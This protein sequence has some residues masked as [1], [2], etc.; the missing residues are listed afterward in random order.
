[1]STHGCIFSCLH[2]RIPKT[3]SLGLFVLISS[4]VFGQ[5][6]AAQESEHAAGYETISVDRWR[7]DLHFLVDTLFRRHANAF[8]TRS[9]KDLEDS[10]RALNDGLS[11]M[12]PTERIVEFARF[13]A[14]VGDGHTRMWLYE[15]P[16]GFHPIRFRRYPIRVYWFEEGLYVLGISLQSSALLGARVDSIDNV[17]VRE[18]L[19]R[20]GSLI[21]HDNP[22]GVLQYSPIYLTTPEVLHALKL[23]DSM[24]KSTWVA[25]TTTGRKLSTVLEPVSADYRIQYLSIPGFASGDRLFQEVDAFTLKRHDATVVAQ[26]NQMSNSGKTKLRDFA[27]DLL[28]GLDSTKARR[29]VVDLRYNSGG[30]ASL[31]RP[32]IDEVAKRPSVNRRGGLFVL[33]GRAT[34]SAALW[35]CLDFQRRTNA[36]LIGEPTSGKPNGFGET[37]EFVLPNTGL[38]FSVATRF[39]QRSTPD[40]TRPWLPPDVGVSLSLA[41]VVRGKDRAL[42]AALKWKPK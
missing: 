4:S 7:E 6:S 16:K 18:A 2:R 38:R 27:E 14:L 19:E 36:I 32:F 24:M 12:T 37:D 10:A 23:S 9:R 20:V 3:L 28:K 5:S 34:F 39:N 30:D 42:E 40:D 35:N 25:T 1:M 33:I 15:R 17:P 13:L 11:R 31:L 21:S 26:I 22:Q 41:D 29:L 8:H